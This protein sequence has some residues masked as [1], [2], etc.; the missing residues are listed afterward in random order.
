MVQH[1]YS[2]AD[3]KS[4]VIRRETRQRQDNIE[5]VEDIKL[6]IVQIGLLNPIVVREEEGQL[7]LVAGERRLKAHLQLDLPTIAYTHI[8]DLS[9]PEAEVIELEE[10]VKRSELSWRDNVKAIARIHQLHKATNAKWSVDDTAKSISLHKTSIHKALA[11]FAAFPTGRIDKSESMEQA[12]NTIQRFAERKAEA[13][14]GQLIVQGSDIFNVEDLVEE[15]TE[16]SLETPIT[17]E[18]FAAD[19]DELLGEDLLDAEVEGAPISGPAVVAP[20]EQA[21]TLPP[22]PAIVAAYVM[23]T[24]P[25]ICAEF[26]AWARNFTG[27]KFNL[28]HCDFPYGNYRGGDSK[29]SMSALDTEEF[30]DNQESVYWNLVS[31]LTENLDRIMS[32]SAHMIFWFNMNFYTET[33]RRL[34]QTGLFV[35]DHPLIWHKTGGAGGL[36][37]VPGGGLTYPRRTYDTALLAVRGNRPPIRS[38]LASYASPTVGGKIHPSQKP[39]PMLRQFLSMYVD[40]TT[41]ILDPTC[42]SAAALRAAEDLGAEYILGLE[43]DP[44]YASIAN[45]KTLQAR[46]LRRAGQLVKE[47]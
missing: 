28:I 26:G 12:Y 45:T 46:I 31:I 5:D 1:K 14:V 15:Q 23:P 40:G 11:V 43:L 37:V 21:V 25:V 4:I 30:Y 33:V 41:R 16:F 32:Y 3:P 22:R 35:F 6:S 19:L 44:N 2:H 7:I 47:G 20:S 29:G 39:E 8:S 18:E 38:G 42:G 24:E 10:N 36:G 13:I 17:A 34:R 27:P 9:A